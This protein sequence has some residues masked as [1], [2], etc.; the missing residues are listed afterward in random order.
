MKNFTHKQR[1]RLHFWLM[2]VWI[3]MI[4]VAF[5]SGLAFVVPFVAFISLYSN[6]LCH[7]DGFAAESAA[8]EG[9]ANR[10]SAQP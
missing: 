5:L 7:S 4:P 1:A 3:V 10:F 9:E 2:I 6:V 8:A